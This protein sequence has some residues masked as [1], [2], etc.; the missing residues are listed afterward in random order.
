MMRMRNALPLLPLLTLPIF[1]GP[2]GCQSDGPATPLASDSRV[3]GPAQIEQFRVELPGVS[4]T[5]SGAWVVVTPSSSS[6]VAQYRLPPPAGETGDASLVVYYFGSSGAGNVRANLDRWCGQFEQPDGG[7][8]TDAARIEQREINGL[9]VHTVDL[10]GTYVAETSPGSGVHRNEPDSRLL[11]AVVLTEAGPYYIKLIGPAL[12]VG[13]WK[14]TYD[15][16]L[17]TLQPATIDGSEK[18][19]GAKHQ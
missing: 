7:S 9:E 3:I 6:R 14:T 15:D 19:V 17:A 18:T 8:S 5:A 4:F 16:L 13:S 12:T 1:L 2:G 10:A 11:A